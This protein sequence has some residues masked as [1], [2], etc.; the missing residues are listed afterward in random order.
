MIILDKLFIISRISLNAGS[1]RVS[2]SD[3]TRSCRQ[4]ERLERLDRFLDVVDGNFDGRGWKIGQLPNEIQLRNAI[5]DLEGIEY[6]KY[7]FI[8]TF[9]SDVTGWKETD[10]EIIKANL[11]VL[12]LSG[13]HEIL[14]SVI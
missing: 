11:Y 5:I 3:R 7:I 6:I 4:K 12:P 14:I 10:M 8:S 13:E 2:V 9:T 1:D